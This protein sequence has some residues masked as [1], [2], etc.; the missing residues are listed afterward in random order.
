MSMEATAGKNINHPGK[1]YQIMAYEIAKRVGKLKG[2][3]EGIVKLTSQIGKPLDDP[4]IAS[5][6]VDGNNPKIE[7][8]VDSVFIDRSKIEM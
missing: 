7:G 4:Q 8:I 6:A 2:V 3:R 5:I 1:L